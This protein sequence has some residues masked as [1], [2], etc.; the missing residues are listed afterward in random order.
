MSEEAAAILQLLGPVALLLPHGRPVRLGARPLGLLTLLALQMPRVVS[1][2]RLIADLWGPTPPPSARNAV[3]V[4]VSALRS[5][6]GPAALLTQAPGYRLDPQHVTTDVARFEQ[7]WRAGLADADPVRRSALLAQALALWRGEPLAN[8]EGG[9]FTAAARALAEQH[10][11]VLDER[12]DADLAAGRAASLVAELTELVRTPALRERRW[13]QLALALY[14]SGRQAEALATLQHVR[15]ALDEQLGLTPSA[16]LRVLEMRMLRQDAH[17]DEASRPVAQVPASPADALAPDLDPPLP[18]APAPLSTTPLLGRDAELDRLLEVVDDPAVRLVTVLGTGGIGKTRIAQ[19]VA[20]QRPGALW[21]SLEATTDPTTVLEVI[22]GQLGV[23]GDA[24]GVLQGPLVHLL[25][26]RLLILDNLE[27]LLA[28][29]PL[30][31]ALLV[32]VPQLT[33]LT[34]SRVALQAVGEAEFQLSPLSA[35]DH[36]AGVELFLDRARAAGA[37]LTDD[38]RTRAQLAALVAR[39]DGLPLAIELAAARARLL[40]PAALLARLSATGDLPPVGGPRPERHRSLTATMDWSYGLLRPAAQQVLA[41]LSVFADGFTLDAA[42]Q[43]CAPLGVD[44]ARCL[45]GPVPP[46]GDRPVVCGRAAG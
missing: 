35:D 24:D 25:T 26:G 12:I 43:V 40:P 45:R 21:V 32:A 37:A 27:H 9:S 46:A 17:L 14:R 20:E 23:H 4:H 3:Q 31:Q 29:A 18:R 36:G 34:T 33:V 13:C 44:A 8:L 1:A 41:R 6:L 5:V 28:G 10:Q 7:A 2:D 30:V 39:L 38:P 15:R 42:E 19:A 11:H 22:A 16:D